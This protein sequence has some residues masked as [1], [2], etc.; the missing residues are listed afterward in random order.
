MI[1][2]SAVA[3]GRKNVLLFWILWNKSLPL[4]NNDT[5]WSSNM[6]LLLTA[7]FAETCVDYV[8]NPPSEPILLAPE[9]HLKQ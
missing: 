6:T 1:V 4:T 7:V 5:W 9:K 2:H 8:D 3:Q